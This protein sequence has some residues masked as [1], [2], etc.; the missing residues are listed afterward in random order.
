MLMK[1]TVPCEHAR[2]TFAATSPD[3]SVAIVE[4]ADEDLANVVAGAGYAADAYELD[5][6]D[7]GG[8]PPGMYGQAPAPPTVPGGVIRR[9]RRRA[10]RRLGR[11]A[12]RRYRQSYT[13]QPVSP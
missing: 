2:E 11:R 5:D 13:Q 7:L 10:A 6:M 1:K 9:H 8:A 12:A 3:Y 4:L